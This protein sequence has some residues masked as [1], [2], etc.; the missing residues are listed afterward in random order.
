LA[1][2]E[3]A[4]KRE[5]A[6]RR[7]QVASSHAT[8]G[9]QLLSSAMKGQLDDEAVT[10]L[11][12]AWRSPVTTELLKTEARP[13][14]LR[15]LW[16][17]TEAARVMSGDGQTANLAQEA[18]K[19]ARPFVSEARDAVEKTPSDVPA[20]HGLFYA[21]LALPEGDV[22]R[23]ECTKLLML[24][25][26][27]QPA[28]QATRLAAEVLLKSTDNLDTDKLT[29][30]LSSNATEDALVLAAL[31]C[32]AAGPESWQTYRRASRELL[33]QTPVPGC[34]VVLINNL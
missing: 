34:V 30:A 8:F 26:Q 1:N 24:V 6:R 9:W 17:V 29:L 25:S 20:F 28:L 5:T 32:R 15:S 22:L 16:M 19:S 3:S 23:N 10:E 14:V 11:R 18:M 21:T 33:R 12:I 4:E 2:R 13:L 31:A 7:S 27:D